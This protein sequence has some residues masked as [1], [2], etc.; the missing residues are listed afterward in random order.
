MVANG[1]AMQAIMKATQEQ[2]K[3][4]RG[5]AVKAHKLTESMKMDSLSMKTVRSIVTDHLPSTNDYGDRCFNH[6]LPARDILRS[7][8]LDAILQQQ[9]LDQRSISILAVD[10]PN[11]S[12]HWPCIRLLPLSEIS[13]QTQNRHWR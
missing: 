10:C 5:L 12:L 1:A 3:V 9:R 11:D 13:K 4:S 7:P 2:T 6:V 8:T